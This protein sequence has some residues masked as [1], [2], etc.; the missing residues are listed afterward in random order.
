MLLDDKSG[1][2]RKVSHSSDIPGNPKQDLSLSRT[3]LIQSLD[4]KRDEIGQ[5][6]KNYNKVDVS[7][8]GRI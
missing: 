8:I 4:T 7:V 3:P 1:R 6:T 2:V 5:T